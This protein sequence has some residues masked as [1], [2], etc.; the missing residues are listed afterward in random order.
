MGTP[1]PGVTKGVPKKEEKGNEKKR[2]KKE[3]KKGKGKRK[4]GTKWRKDEKVNQY[5]ET[6]AI[7]GRI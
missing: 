5:N 2:E 3:E 7:Q 6:G 1:A 4:E